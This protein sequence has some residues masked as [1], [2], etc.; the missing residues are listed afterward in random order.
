MAIWNSMDATYF[1]VGGAGFIGSHFVDELLG[2]KET[3]QV[4]VFDN[5]S[6]G[7]RWHLAHHRADSRLKVVQ[8]DVKN[9]D[10]LQSAMK[11][12]STVI[13]L[14]SNPDI[15]RAISEPDIDFREGTY[16]TQN[17]LEAIRVSGVSL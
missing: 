17:V 10:S 7:K 8:A 13:H 6:S 2:R 12:H 14:A 3:L 11:G 15:A 1:I 16:L 9:L 4:T 5:F